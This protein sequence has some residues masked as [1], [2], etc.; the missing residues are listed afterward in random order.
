MSARKTVVAADV[1]GTKTD[2]GL[3]ELGTGLELVRDRRYESA[4]HAGLEEVLADFLGDA[5]VDAAGVAGAGPVRDGAIKTTNLPWLIS[6]ES[7]ARQLGGCPVFLL[8]DLEAAA[9]G[10]LTLGED[11]FETLNPGTSVPEKNCAVLA[12]GTGLGQ[13]I[14]FWTGREYRPYATE[15]GHVGFAPRNDEQL[16]LLRFMQRRHASVSYERVVSGMGLGEVLE[17]VSTEL[18]IPV[19]RDVS[20]RV[21]SADAGPVIGAA[22]VAGSCE[23]SAKTIELFFAILAARAG[24]LALSVMAT[25][26]VYLAGGVVPKLLPVLN[27]DRFRKDFAGQGPFAELLAGVPVRLVLEPQVALLGAASTAANG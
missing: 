3:F 10:V 1:G 23:A 2:V 25:G 22:A 18:K 27:R 15:G 4:A 7:I 17:F 6:G 16:G 5:R 8:N 11:S 9:A 21:A 14:L 19:S 26:G 20:D 24:D 13:S 12:A